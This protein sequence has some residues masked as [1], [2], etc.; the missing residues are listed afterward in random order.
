MRRRLFKSAGGLE[1]GEGHEGLEFLRESF[2]GLKR[3]RELAEQARRVEGIEGRKEFVRRMEG[4]EGKELANQM[5]QLKKK[6]LE[7]SEGRE[8]EFLK[9]KSVAEYMEAEREK[10]RDRLKGKGNPESSKSLEGL[11]GALKGEG[12]SEPPRRHEAAPAA[13]R[14]LGKVPRAPSPTSPHVPPVAAHVP[15]PHVPPSVSRVLGKVPRALP[16]LKP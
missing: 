7:H 13:A 15:A 5:E 10:W 8:D 16:R 9:G 11:R 6:I 14:V 1:G 3:L 12:L 4:T 2:E